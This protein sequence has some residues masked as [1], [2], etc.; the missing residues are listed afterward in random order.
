MKK[1]IEE[2]SSFWLSPESLHRLIHLY[3]QETCGKEQEFI[4]GEKPLKTL[5]LSQEAR[6][7]ILRDFRAL[8]RQTTTAYREWESWLKGGNPHLLVTFKSECAS[9][10]PEAAFIMPLHPLVKQA[11]MSFDW[12]KRV[13]T[14]LKITSDEVPVGQYEFAI[15]QWKFHGIREDL[16]LQPVASSAAV[17]QHLVDFLEKAEEAPQI[18]LDGIGISAWDDLDAQHYW[19]WAEVRDKHRR[20]TQELAEYRRESLSTSHRARMSLLGEQLE[21][22]DDEK[23]RRMRQSQISAAEA[24]YARRIQELDIAMERADVTADPVAY[25]MIEIKG[26]VPNAK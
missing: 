23:I 7:A 5:R 8:P 18:D 12:K 3:L 22:A 6:A 11:G 14:A 20:R 9:Q 19:L 21:Q 15:Y 10:N 4:L 26:V 17:T 25:G 1:E 24:D 16:V 2:A 13:V